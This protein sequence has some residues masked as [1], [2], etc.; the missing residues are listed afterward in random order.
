MPRFH[1]S[2]YSA[3]SVTVALAF[4]AWFAA[5]ALDRFA[6]Q[7]AAHAELTLFALTLVALVNIKQDSIALVAGLLA[8]ALL[9]ALLQGRRGGA[10]RW[11]R[12]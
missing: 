10:G 5:R 8:S 3:D 1:F 7:R 12:C 11:P 6:A 9:L 4:A 2:A